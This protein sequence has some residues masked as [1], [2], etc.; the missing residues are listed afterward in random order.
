MYNE[1]VK[2]FKLSDD[3]DAIANNKLV[4]KD[5]K[6]KIKIIHKYRNQL[7]G[8]ILTI[9]SLTFNNYLKE[10]MLTVYGEGAMKI[11][12]IKK[13][14]INEINNKW[15]K[16]KEIKFFKKYEDIF[17]L[18][19]KNDSP[20]RFNYTTVIATFYMLIRYLREEKGSNI[21]LIIDLICNLFS[22]EEKS[23]QIKEDRYG[24]IKSRKKSILNKVENKFKRFILDFN[25]VNK[26]K[27]PLLINIVNILTIFL[28]NYSIIPKKKLKYLDFYYDYISKIFLDNKFYLYFNNI[29]LKYRLINSSDD[30]DYSKYINEVNIINDI[31]IDN[32]SYLSNLEQKD[33]S[34]LKEVVNY[35]FDHIMDLM[36]MKK[37][38]KKLIC[39]QIVNDFMN[40]DFIYKLTFI[41]IYN[42]I[43]SLVYKSNMNIDLETG[44]IEKVNYNYL[45]VID[46]SKE[47]KNHLE[48][49]IFDNNINFS[50]E[51]KVMNNNWKLSTI[52]F[53]KPKFI[54][55]REYTILP[56]H[57][58][59]DQICKIQDCE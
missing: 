59:M 55:N 20:R 3:V 25:Y 11:D 48:K 22:I 28:Y 15:R 14:Y 16:F 51:L 13:C 37:K 7:Q 42:T 41:L 4:I 10:N 9:I 18:G 5:S 44:T 34:D 47:V 1:L 49:I 30:S 53:N 12:Q 21:I 26:K 40:I 2:F 58:S 23:N 19:S 24:E 57:C 8:W 35:Y 36:T 43:S 31:F 45:L 52:L 17:Y 29:R 56:K 33:F 38:E 27:T 39:P 6:E 50:E 46:N 32:I 54:S